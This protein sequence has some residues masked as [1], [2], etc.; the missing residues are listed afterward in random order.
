[1]RLQ[2]VAQFTSPECYFHHVISML[3][4]RVRLDS[5]LIGLSG[6]WLAI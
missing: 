5:Q 3:L 4:V 1:M 6:L 2:N